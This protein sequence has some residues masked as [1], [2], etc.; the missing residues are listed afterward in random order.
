M[1]LE[2]LIARFR[3]D[4]TD[5]V[6]QGGLFDDEW[7][8]AWLN[9]AQQE[10]AIRGRLLYEA[11]QPSIC[12]ITTA[13]GVTVYPLHE[14][15]YELSSTR[16]RVQG[17]LTSKPLELTT[18]EDLDRVR[19]NWRDDAQGCPRY[20]IQDDSRLTIW[21][22][23]DSAGTVLL[24]GYRLPLNAMASDNDKPEINAAHHR[25][26]VYWALHMAF[27]RPDADSFDPQRAVTAEK[28]F[29]RYFG[30]RPDSDLRR[31]SRHDQPQSTKAFWG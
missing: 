21:P 19:P 26:L 1:T 24:E 18:R 6:L 30:I 8:T 10:A 5:T 2:D 9:D 28:A 11:S 25:H 4:S 31:A 13:P 17:D 23:P 14:S 27:S 20:I 22:A 7:I 29:T 3:I 15:L 16:Y 12:E